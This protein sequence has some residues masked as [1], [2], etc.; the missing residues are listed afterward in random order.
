MKVITHTTTRAAR[1]KN[2]TL[3]WGVHEFPAGK[4]LVALS[5]EGICWIGLNCGEKDL[6]QNWAGANLIEDQ[7]MTEKPAREIASAWKK[8]WPQNADGIKQPLVLYGTAFQIKVWKEL[9]KIKSGK[10]VTYADIA[11]KVGAPTAVRAVGSA[12]GKN[13]L[14][15][16]V[17]CHR[18]VNTSGNKISYAWGP[19]VKKALLKAEGVTV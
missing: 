1:G 6:A 14:S 17:P 16:I 19:A 11:R 12:V 5:A 10:T 13:T 2:L 9:L 4:L 3:V 7:K 8:G 15:L 18:V